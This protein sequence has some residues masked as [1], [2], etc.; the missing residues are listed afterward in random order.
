MSLFTL[1]KITRTRYMIVKKHVKPGTPGAEKVVEESRQ[2]YA[3]RRDGKKQIKVKLYSDKAA[4]LTQMA[5]MNT[6]LERGQA[7]MTDPRKEHLDR[8]AIEHLE[9]FLHVMRAKGKSEKDKDRKESILRA[10]VGK[11]H[12]LSDLKHT[13]VDSYLNEV[14]GS[15]GNKK[16]HLSAI[17]VWVAWLVKK[18]RIPT[19]P[20]DR[21]ERDPLGARA[22]GNPTALIEPSNS[23]V[24]GGLGGPRPQGHLT[25][26]SERYEAVRGPSP[27]SVSPPRTFSCVSAESWSYTKAN[28]FLVTSN[29]R[30]LRESALLSGGPHIQEGSE[31]S[32]SQRG[33]GT[34]KLS[35]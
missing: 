21:V 31:Y 2:W 13:A 35:D 5:K 12:K 14:G 20:L 18:D 26:H 4:S 10:F 33:C 25:T 15:T 29:P 11:L 1:L 6:A 9:E 28:G 32:F 7:G 24:G 8:K 22:T 30:L 19:N 16:K 17:S 23:P 34:E 3:Y 27:L